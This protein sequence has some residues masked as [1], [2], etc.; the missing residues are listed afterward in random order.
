MSRKRMLTELTVGLSLLCGLLVFGRAQISRFGDE[1]TEAAREMVAALGGGTMAADGERV[2]VG[3]GR[4]GVRASPPPVS[5]ERPNV[6]EE[7]VREREIATRTPET[8]ALAAAAVEPPAAPDPE[9]VRDSVKTEVAALGPLHDELIEVLKAIQEALTDPEEKRQAEQAATMAGIAK[10]QEMGQLE[11]D[12]AAEPEWRVS[13][14][15]RSAGR[16]KARLER[17][18]EEARATLARIRGG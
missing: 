8:E 12:A 16:A 1:A 7:A 10:R 18:I 2:A 11:A 17:E 14:A 6:S 4:G 15:G 13:G 9:A 5:P 3:G